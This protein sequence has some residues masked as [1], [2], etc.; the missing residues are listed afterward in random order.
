MFGKKYMFRLKNIY[1]K[2]SYSQKAIENSLYVL[3]FNSNGLLSSFDTLPKATQELILDV[4]EEYVD[5][6]S[7]AK[8]DG[9]SVL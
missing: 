6:L 8:M 5:I 3:R 4:T 7:L 2:F 1:K 9:Y